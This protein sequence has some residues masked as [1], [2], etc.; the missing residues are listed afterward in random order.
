MLF[1][2]SVLPLW[3]ISGSCCWR[4]HRFLCTHK[5][6]K[7]T[8]C[9]WMNTNLSERRR[10]RKTKVSKRQ[11]RLVSNSRHPWFTVEAVQEHLSP[12]SH[13]QYFFDVL[14]KSLPLILKVPSLNTSQVWPFWFCVFQ[15]PFGPVFGIISLLVALVPQSYIQAA[16]FLFFFCFFLIN[17]LKRTA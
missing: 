4:R 3:N 16:S 13:I 6:V 10:R 8:L 5:E 9:S 2:S 12:S 1:F 17:P 7:R 14:M 11:T 15:A